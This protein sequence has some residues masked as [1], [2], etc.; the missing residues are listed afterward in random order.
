MEYSSQHQRLH[1]LLSEKEH[2][3]W[4]WNGTLLND[5]DH[6]VETM[7][8][9]LK[10][11]ALPSLDRGRY[12]QIFEFPV[13][14]YYE[15][16][17]FDFEKESFENLCHR[18]VDRFM[19]GFHSLPLISGIEMVL[20]KLHKA[21]LKQSVLSATDQPNLESMVA[22]FNLQDVF[23]YVFGINDKMASSKIDRGHELLRVSQMDPRKTIIVGDTLHDLEVANELGIDAVLVGHGHQ[24]PIKLGQ[25]HH[26]VI[27]E[28]L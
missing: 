4:D 5:V 24:C 16:L 3:I 19:A 9:L 2:I 11:H 21:G 17:G 1:G 23:M 8:H 14:R 28:R 20:R 7:N 10:D 6:A 13:R 12:Q 25:F 26:N 22:H 18:F 27:L 15:A